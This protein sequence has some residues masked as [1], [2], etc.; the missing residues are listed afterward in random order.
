MKLTENSDFITY[1]DEAIQTAQTYINQRVDKTV[2]L[3][4]HQYELKITSDN[5]FALF[6]KEALVGWV[7]LEPQ[8]IK[9]KRYHLV[10]IIYLIPSVRKPKALLIMLNAVRSE[11]DAPI[12]IND[13]VFNDGVAMIAALSKRDAF[14]VN[15]LDVKA[16]E[17]SPFTGEVPNDSK[18]AIIVEGFDF[19]LVG[20]Y[21][22][23]GSP[24][25]PLSY[26]LFD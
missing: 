3:E 10:K 23:P 14:K 19:P 20:M 6:K 5:Y 25:Q 24:P 11:I 2:P 9:G 26:V 12:L 15:I 16:G 4:N 17:V 1:D 18:K 13:G 8:Q 21:E 7:R 22:A